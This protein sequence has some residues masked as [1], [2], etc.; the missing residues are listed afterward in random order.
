MKWR[1]REEWQ[2]MQ[3]LMLMPLCIMSSGCACV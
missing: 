1:P 2:G 3:W